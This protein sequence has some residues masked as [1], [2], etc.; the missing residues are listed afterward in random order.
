MEFTSIMLFSILLA[1]SIYLIYCLFTWVPKS[2]QIQRIIKPYSHVNPGSHIVRKKHLVVTNERIVEKRQE[3]P[4]PQPGRTNASLRF[5]SA[6]TAEFIP[7]A[8]FSVVR[9]QEFSDNV[10]WRG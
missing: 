4:L 8:R 10:K 7:K 6:S 5:P 3:T 2:T 9:T 1:L